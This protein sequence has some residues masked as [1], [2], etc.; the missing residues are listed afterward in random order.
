MSATDGPLASVPLR[1]AHRL[2]RGRLV[3]VV[4]A[5]G[6]ERRGCIEEMRDSLA[7][8]RYID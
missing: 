8:V 6:E 1:Q 7:A 4:F 3:S 2:Y 5:D